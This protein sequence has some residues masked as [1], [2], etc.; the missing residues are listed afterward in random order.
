MGAYAERMAGEGRL[1][2]T[3]T[4]IVR[5][6]FGEYLAQIFGGIPMS[7]GEI[8]RPADLGLTGGDLAK[9]L[10]PAVE[11]LI[12]TGNHHA[13]ANRFLL[14]RFATGRMIDETGNGATPNLH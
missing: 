10:T 6:A 9:A 5:A 13:A 1:G 12:A 4:L 14:D 3:E 7:Q 11:H 2:D 8:V